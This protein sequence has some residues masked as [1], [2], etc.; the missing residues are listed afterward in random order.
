M[1]GH[2]RLCGEPVGPGVFRCTCKTDKALELL[3]DCW[4]QFSLTV[5]V[6]GE[7][8]MSDGCLST[9]ERLAD[10]LVKNGRLV[11]HP[12]KRLYRYTKESKYVE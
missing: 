3:T 11:K 10:Y 7:S 5:E 9:L 4:G 12:T 2:C 1:S 6:D 8:W